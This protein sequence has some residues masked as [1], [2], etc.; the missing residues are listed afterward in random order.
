MT[1]TDRLRLLA[2]G[3]IAVVSIGCGA[4]T[5]ERGVATLGEVPTASLSDCIAEARAYTVAIG[6]LTGADTLT[7][8]LR[9]VGQGFEAC[10]AARRDIETESTSYA[11]ESETRNLLLE[12]LID[13][14]DTMSLHTI[15]LAIG[16]A[17]PTVFD[18][19]PAGA[20][21]FRGPVE[22]LLDTLEERA[23]LSDGA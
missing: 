3:L 15:V 22:H 13:L 2:G 4:G 14:L 9:A 20:E 16:V 7:D 5:P 23:G 19:G 12:P 1:I 8:A 6:T 10:S 21:G 18:A 11:D 17:D